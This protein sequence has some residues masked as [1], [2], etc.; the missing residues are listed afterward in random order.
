MHRGRGPKRCTGRKSAL[1]VGNV[2][3]G[4]RSAASL[5]SRNSGPVILRCC[6]KHIESRFPQ[7]PR[8]KPSRILIAIVCQASLN[9]IPA[10]PVGTHVPNKRLTLC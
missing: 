9:R 10:A 6:W 5:R 7:R 8:V 3:Q 2:Q 4:A 1:K